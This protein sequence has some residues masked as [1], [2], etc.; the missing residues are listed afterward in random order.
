MMNEN[1]NVDL[2]IFPKSSLA[3]FVLSDVESQVRLDI[4]S[5]FLSLSRARALL[6]SISRAPS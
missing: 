4:F 6:F 5:F 3:R 2:I 1:G